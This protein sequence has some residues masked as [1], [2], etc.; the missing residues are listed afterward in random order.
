MGAQDA[1][2]ERK[3]AAEKKPEEETK[4][5]AESKEKP[6][7][8]NKAQEAGELSI[9]TN[10]HHHN[11]G[12]NLYAVAKTTAIHQHM[13]NQILA[14]LNEHEQI[15]KASAMQHK[16]SEDR[17]TM[18]ETAISK[19]IMERQVQPQTQEVKKEGEVK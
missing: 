13:L 19:L 9:L 7:E 3:K 1:L 4:G 15:H 17:H 16:T 10:E 8:K 2:I 6:T 11:M 14:K 18:N 5:N 12:K